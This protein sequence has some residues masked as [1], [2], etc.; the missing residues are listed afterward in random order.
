MR[1]SGSHDQQC[2]SRAAY[3]F[4]LAKRILDLLRNFGDPPLCARLASALRN[5]LKPGT[6]AIFLIAMNEKDS[7]DLVLYN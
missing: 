5:R 4:E 7:D 2:Q 1:S 6:K 3:V